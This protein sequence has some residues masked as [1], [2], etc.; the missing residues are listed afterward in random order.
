MTQELKYPLVNLGDYIEVQIHPT[1]I[2]NMTLGG[3]S[4]IIA[5]SCTHPIDTFRIK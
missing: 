3:A 1:D 2:I 5:A 4:S